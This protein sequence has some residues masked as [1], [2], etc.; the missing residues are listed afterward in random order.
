MVSKDDVT[1]HVNSKQDKKEVKQSAVQQDKL[2]L[3]SEY[4]FD[5]VQH[6]NSECTRNIGYRLNSARKSFHALGYSHP[7]CYCVWHHMTKAYQIVSIFVGTPS[8]NHI[9]SPFSTNE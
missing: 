2:N 7:S 8:T 5:S 3:K 4:R 1:A 6:R 9:N